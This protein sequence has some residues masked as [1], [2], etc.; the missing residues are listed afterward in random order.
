MGIFGGKKS[1]VVNQTVPEPQKT[2]EPDEI[3][4]AR[5]AEDEDLFGS[6]TPD[7]RVDRPSTGTVAG[8]SGLKLM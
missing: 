7:L 4:S 1:S 5:K 3:G 6:S 8:G 2:A